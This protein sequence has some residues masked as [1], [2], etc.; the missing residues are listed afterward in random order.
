MRQRGKIAFLGTVVEGEF[1]G[2]PTHVYGDNNPGRRLL[3]HELKV[4]DAL[5]HIPRE[6]IIRGN[7]VDAA[8]RADAE[9][10]LNGVRYFWELDTG[11]LTHSQVLRRWQCYRDINESMTAFLLVVT[12]SERRMAGL[13]D[14]AK[15]AV[16]NVAL[17]TTLR[18]IID[19]T[20]YEEIW[21]DCSGRKAALPRNG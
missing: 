18:K 12:C 13:I 4:T 15:H 19:H 1:G 7:N 6:N 21:I 16:G 11:S 5:W 8:V 3:R 14:R 2:R 9:H 10:E 17:F 20:P